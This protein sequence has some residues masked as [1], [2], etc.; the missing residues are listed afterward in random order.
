MQSTTAAPITIITTMV[1]GG[2][3]ALLGSFGIYSAAQPSALTG[4]QAEYNYGVK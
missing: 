3:L 1:V 2:I 4:Q